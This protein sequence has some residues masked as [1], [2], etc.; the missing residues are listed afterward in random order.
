MQQRSHVILLY[1]FLSLFLTYVVVRQ[2]G[3]TKAAFV[4]HVIKHY[5][6]RGGPTSLS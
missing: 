1:H 3:V 2:E 6:N 5:N 4:Q